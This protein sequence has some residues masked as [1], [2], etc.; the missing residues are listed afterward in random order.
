MVVAQNSGGEKS[1]CELGLKV[2]KTGDANRW[3]V[4]E[5]QE[6]LKALARMKGQRCH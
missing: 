6:D 2:V 4:G 1:D 5:R 3:A